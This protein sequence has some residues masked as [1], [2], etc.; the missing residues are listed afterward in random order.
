MRRF[1]RDV[2]GGLGVPLLLPY[3]ER[4][5]MV[6]P[7]FGDVFARTIPNAEL[8]RL[9]EASHFAHVDAVERFLPPVLEFLGR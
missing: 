6:P 3:A 2:A 4:D 8:V 5:P 1:A 7:R 9:S